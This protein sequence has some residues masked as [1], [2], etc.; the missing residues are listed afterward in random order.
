MKPEKRPTDEQLDQWLRN[1]VVPPEL[2][3]KLKQ[4]QI[5]AAFR[6]SAGN[7]ADVSSIGTPE[8]AKGSPVSWGAMAFA[9]S[10]LGIGL[11]L[12]FAFWPNRST[13]QEMA[14]VNT[15]PKSEK[16][17]MVPDSV[18]LQNGLAALLAG[19]ETLDRAIHEFEV[20]QLEAKLSRLEQSATFQLNQREIESMIAAMSEEYAIPLGVPEQQVRSRMA[21]VIEQYPG[22]R[23]AEIAIGFLKQENLQ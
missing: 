5:Q 15:E 16:R 17:S 13:R 10:L 8:A 20:A 7:S 3:S 2:K 6:N 11:Y 4:I 9:A 14:A 23:G 12:A 19:Q 18:E 22:T 21:Q 1:V